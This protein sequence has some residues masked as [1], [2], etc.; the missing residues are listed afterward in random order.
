MDPL[1]Q[2]NGLSERTFGL[3]GRL[4]T[5]LVATVAAAIHELACGEQ[6]SCA[7]QRSDRR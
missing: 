7:S 3:G 1:R 5:S 4:P 6:A 2:L